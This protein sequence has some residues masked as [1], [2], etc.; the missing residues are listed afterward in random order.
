MVSFFGFV[1]RAPPTQLVKYLLE[2]KLFRGKVAWRILTKILTDIFLCTS[3]AFRDHS[4]KGKVRA[5]IVACGGFEK[6][7]SP[8]QR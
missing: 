4:A 5:T 8:A 2:R 6:R 1:A 7:R 3:Y